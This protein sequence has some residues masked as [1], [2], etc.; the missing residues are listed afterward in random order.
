MRRLLLLLLMFALTGC[1]APSAT[2]GTGKP[3]SSRVSDDN[4][5]SSQ[6]RALEQ[7]EQVEQLIGDA[8]DARNAR[9]D[10]AAAGLR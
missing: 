4:V 2:P 6:V 5:F 3:A 10:E 1:E 9:M 7:A 8:Y